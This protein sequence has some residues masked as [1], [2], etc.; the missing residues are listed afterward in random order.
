M[1]IR[2]GSRQLNLLS[3]WNVVAPELGVGALVAAAVG[4]G[5]SVAVGVGVGWSV[6][7]GVGLGAPVASG[8]GLADVTA[9]LP[10][11]DPPQ[12]PS[13]TTLRMTATI[14]RART[15]VKRSGGEPVTDARLVAGR[16]H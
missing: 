9:E 2:T 12:P 15:L 13:A 4:V 6:A 1:I 7:V 3:T 10:T 8:V 11:G 16:M 14:I 5:G